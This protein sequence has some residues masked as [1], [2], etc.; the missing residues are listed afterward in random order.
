MITN[1]S[2]EED[3][4][5]LMREYCP[6]LVGSDNMMNM[7]E[8]SPSP[9]TIVHQ[10]DTSIA[11]LTLYDDDKN[12]NDSLHTFPILPYQNSSEHLGSDWNDM[13]L[14]MN[15]ENNPLLL[16]TPK[17]PI[18]E[19][20]TITMNGN[21]NSNGSSGSS[22]GNS[23][24]KRKISSSCSITSSSEDESSERCSPILQSPT[25]SDGKKICGTAINISSA[26]KKKCETEE[27]EDEVELNRLNQIS[28]SEL[29]DD[30]K[31]LKKKL[32][33]RQ[34]A[35]RSRENKRHELQV[36]QDLNSQ[37]TSTC[38][39]LN[40]EVNELKVLVQQLQQEN[41]LLKSELKTKSNN[42]ISPKIENMKK[43]SVLLFMA[44]FCVGFVCMFTSQYDRQITS[45]GLYNVPLNVVMDQPKLI[46]LNVHHHHRQGM[47]LLTAPEREET[48]YVET[49]ERQHK[50]HTKDFTSSHSF[51]GDQMVKRQVVFP[52][53]LKQHFSPLHN[54]SIQTGTEIIRLPLVGD[55]SLQ[56]SKQLSMIPTAL[57]SGS[58]SEYLYNQMKGRGLEGGHTYQIPQ[59]QQI[60]DDSIRLVCPYIYPLI[61]KK[62][63]SESD[64][65]LN[66]S[67][68]DMRDLKS[69]YIKFLIPVQT[70]DSQKGDNGQYGKKIV[71]MAEIAARDILF[72]ELYLEL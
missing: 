11:I 62:E 45:T 51:N 49:E 1:H 17:I 4:D 71:R 10:D 35:R 68:F 8:S 53:P 41:E 37:L 64:Y 25:R 42:N 21:S 30:D 9:V 16:D 23:K 67:P 40:H 70:F 65:I 47:R 57:T 43:K 28:P 26:V 3:E 33:N 72:S 55:F 52:H 56:N 29:T 31:K 5:L 27:I 34:S 20:K 39:Q 60:D 7:I 19:N 44:L 36:S 63:N 12:N 15:D 58:S 61:N 66:D 18:V 14:Y 38:T 32:R 50:Q 59:E 46:P 13:I 24:K 69:K 48:V 22:S 2:E 54:P 6:L